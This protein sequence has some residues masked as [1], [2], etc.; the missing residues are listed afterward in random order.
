MFVVQHQQ[1]EKSNQKQ[2]ISVK[3]VYVKSFFKKTIKLIRCTFISEQCIC[4]LS[5]NLVMISIHIIMSVN[6]SMDKQTKLF[7]MVGEYP[8]HM[9]KN[10]FTGQLL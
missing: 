9:W 7:S 1:P 10:V 5:I 3:H 2:V 8:L 4:V 6:I